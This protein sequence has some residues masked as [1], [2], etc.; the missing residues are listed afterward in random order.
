VGRMLFVAY[1]RSVSAFESA[2]S[3]LESLEVFKKYSD[4]RDSRKVLFSIN[5]II[6]VCSL[7]LAAFSAY[8]AWL[9][10]DP[11]IYSTWINWMGLSIVGLSLA[12]T[13]IVGMRGA[14]LVSLDLLLTYF[15]GITVFVA[16]LL[17]GIVACFDF[18]EYLNVFFAHQVRRSASL[19]FRVCVIACC[20]CVCVCVCLWF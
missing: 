18:Y 4:F 12:V 6:A 14:H 8:L 10:Y 11:N 16:P 2:R 1:T 15:W 7:A 13:C 9:L 19:F 20:V 3:W 5:L 17:L